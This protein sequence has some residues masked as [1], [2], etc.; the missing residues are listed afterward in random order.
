M[1]NIHAFQLRDYVAFRR[2]NYDSI[3]EFVEDH[4]P[5]TKGMVSTLSQYDR[6]LQDKT[7]NNFCR[8]LN[9]TRDDIVNFDP[10]NPNAISINDGLKGRLQDI[11]NVTGVFNIS[12]ALGVS[13]TKVEAYLN[14][15]PVRAPEKMEQRLKNYFAKADQKAIDEPIVTRP[16]FEEPF[17]VGGKLAARADM[18]ASLVARRRKTLSPKR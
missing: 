17:K 11:V 5:L 4:P 16:K 10:E 12:N 9:C 14:D 7:I 15:D 8:A 3:N 6:N 2:Q 1:K 13:V 18:T